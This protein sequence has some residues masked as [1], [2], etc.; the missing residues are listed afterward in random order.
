MTIPYQYPTFEV[1]QPVIIYFE[2]DYH[3]FTSRP[4]VILSRGD[5][6]PYTPEQ[7]EV[8]Y[9]DQR[10]GKNGLGSN[11]TARVHARFIYADGE[12]IAPRPD[13]YGGVGFNGRNGSKCQ[14]AQVGE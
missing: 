3:G 12:P 2:H 11:R 10:I 5:G 4:A 7:Y 9:T 1:D 8:R 13:P 6:N 14:K